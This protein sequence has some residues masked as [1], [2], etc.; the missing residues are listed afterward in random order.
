MLLSCA[1]ACIEEVSHIVQ[2]SQGSGNLVLLL[3][4]DK[5]ECPPLV[6]DLHAQKSHPS[7]K[8]AAAMPEAL[9]SAVQ[10]CT[11]K[12]LLLQQGAWD[13]ISG[14]TFLRNLLAMPL[15]HAKWSTVGPWHVSPDL[16]QA[17][18]KNV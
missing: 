13:D 7:R 9:P 3:D 1:Y 10:L 11:K 16:S 6:D 18:C 12:S 4:R 14:E 2:P 17:P 15:D 8:L 5:F